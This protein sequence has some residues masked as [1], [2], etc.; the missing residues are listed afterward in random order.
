M[1][2]TGALAAVPGLRPLMVALTCC[3]AAATITTICLGV[4][5]YRAGGVV[6]VATVTGVQLLPAT[7]LTPTLMVFADRVA[8]RERVLQVLVVMQTGLLVAA[9]IA[10]RLDLGRLPIIAPSALALSMGTL[11]RPLEVGLLPWLAR[12][13]GELIAANGASAIAEN[14]GALAGPVIAALSLVVAGPSLGVLFA[15]LLLMTAAVLLMTVRLPAQFVDTSSP[16]GPVQLVRDVAQGVVAAAR[17]S[18]MFVFLFLQTL[19]TGALG[20]LVVVMALGVLHFDSGSVGWLWA[21]FGLGGVTGGAA[22][23]V[24]IHGHRL[25]RSLTVALGA[26]GATL[27]L[28]ALSRGGVLA[29]LAMALV[30]MADSLVDVTFFALYPRIYDLRRLGR[31]V[32]GTE[33][34]GFVSIAIGSVVAQLLIHSVGIRGAFAV[35]GLTLAVVALLFAV[36]TGRIDASLP[37]PGPEL[38]LLRALEM[39]AP[40]PMAV[41]EHLATKLVPSE[42]G[43]G[44]VVLREGDPGER[45]HLIVS[46]SAAA[47]VHGVALRTMEPGDAFG[48]IALLRNVQRTATVTATT[49][50]HTLTLDREDFLAAVTGQR[51]AASAAARLA[52]QRLAHG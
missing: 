40:L 2:R 39:F 32:A 42:F 12:T 43:A 33:L 30:G 27:C 13:P 47:S 22:A 1:T 51:D 31:V 7:F 14:A 17:P 18:A 21:A 28:L 36:Q 52:E 16:T 29:Y 6:L 11:F 23:F 26:L 45:F 34:I 50:L 20:V 5:A 37:V 38:D 25:A 19:V 8:H 35:L 24:V 3:K 41:L 15:A 9:T 44:Q 46:G 4:W 10:I 48:E 49:V